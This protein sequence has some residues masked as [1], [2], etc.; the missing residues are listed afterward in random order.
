MGDSK[1]L[2]NVWHF[3]LISFIDLCVLRHTHIQHILNTNHIITIKIHRSQHYFAPNKICVLGRFG[4]RLHVS[5]YLS[6]AHL[7]WHWFDSLSDIY[8]QNGIISVLCRLFAAIV[9]MLAVCLSLRPS[10]TFCYCSSSLALPRRCFI[11][12]LYSRTMQFILFVV[13]AW[14]FCV[15][16]VY[17]CDCYYSHFSLE[18]KFHIFAIHI[19]CFVCVYFFLCF[20]LLYSTC[21]CPPSVDFHP[22]HAHRNRHEIYIIYKEWNITKSAMRKTCTHMQ[23]E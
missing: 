16:Y 12:S 20:L 21:A 17:L 19:L 11:F 4:I 13:C 5:L 15:I 7:L 14:R 2:S 10:S 6:L 22:S 9:V 18:E 8:A 3:L 1:T 23:C